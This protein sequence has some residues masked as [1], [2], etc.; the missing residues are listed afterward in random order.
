MSSY[1]S[2][3]GFVSTM[4]SATSKFPIVS[5]RRSH[6]GYIYLYS[7]FINEV[8]KSILKQDLSFVACLAYSSIQSIE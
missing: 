4:K 5:Y 6:M 2:P 1:L 7:L 8:C 3:L